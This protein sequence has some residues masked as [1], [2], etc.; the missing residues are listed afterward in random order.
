ME[1]NMLKLE[2]LSK[3]FVMHHLGGKTIEGFRSISLEVPQGSS[4]GI[5]GPS[6]SGKSSVLKCIY[7]TYLTTSG[8][9]WYRSSRFGMV[10]MAREAENVVTVL[11]QFEIGSITQFL[12]AIPRVPALEI[13]A[14]PLVNSGSEKSEALRKAAALLE[15]LNIP[16]ALFEAYPATFSGGEQQ[17]IN[18]AR[19]VIKA[20][21]LLILDEPTA[22][23][24]RRA[25]ELVLTILKELRHEGTTMIG[26]FHQPETL[27]EFS[28]ETF[29]M[30]A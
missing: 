12:K 18:I 22:S 1:F 21:R 26:V 24:D 2:N 13:V 25:T 29:I 8:D 20:P 6:G 5:S 28:D 4:M 16:S 9:I 30:P 23:L 27:E 17:R 10:N 3:R 15:R 7:R 11:R 19:A 14:A